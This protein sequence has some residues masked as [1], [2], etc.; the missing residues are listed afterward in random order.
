M[1]DRANSY[2]SIL[3]SSFWNRAVNWGPQSDMILLNSPNLVYNF[4]KMMVA[5][6]SAVIVFFLGHRITPLL[7]PWST[8]TNKES[9]LFE[10]GRLVIRSYEICLKGSVS[11]EMIGFMGGMVG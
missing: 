9:K 7:S 4:L 1:D 10:T 5:T 8:T 3:L 2:L 6:P 11:L